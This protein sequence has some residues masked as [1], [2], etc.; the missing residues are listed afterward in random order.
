MFLN[1][2]V[3]L[4]GVVTAADDFGSTGPAYIQDNSAGIAVYGA[5][6]VSQLTKGDSITITT[7]LG[8]YKALTELIYEE[9][10]SE[11]TVHKN[12][13]L[14]AAQDV[15]IRDILDQ[16][17]NGTECYEGLLC[18]IRG[19]RIDASGTFASGTNYNIFDGA[20]TLI[21]RIDNAVNIVGENIPTGEDVD[22]TGVI[23]QFKSSE[24]YNSGYQIIPRNTADI[25]TMV[26]LPHEMVPRRFA[27]QQNYPNPFNP[28][29]QIAFE[30]PFKEHVLISVHDVYG[31]RIRTLLNKEMPGGVHRILFNGQ[32]LSSG[33]YVYSIVTDT[34]YEARKMI[35]L[36]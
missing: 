1:Q 2:T 16:E 10:I 15:T 24:P 13:A 25:Q 19:V 4:S 17:W 18:R 6:L 26:S 28:E 7:K 11:V 23:G 34:F 33:V 21:L 9:G 5:E 22:I 27:L 3:T 30:L 35:L 31:K 32:N 8:F 36:K 14:P 12:T 20:D 29:T